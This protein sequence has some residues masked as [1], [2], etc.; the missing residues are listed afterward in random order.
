[1]TDH[2][3]TDGKR[4]LST[5][6][7]GIAALEAERDR[8]KDERGRNAAVAIER[9]WRA[10]NAEAE[11]VRLT[12]GIRSIA[13]RR[14]LCYGHS[15]TPGHGGPCCGVAGVRCA[16]CDARRLL[17]APHDQDDGCLDEIVR[18]SEDAG[19]YDMED[20]Q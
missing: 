19:L 15:R 18:V 9:R 1:M 13:A 16:T 20:G 8:L 3:V 11:V 5:T 6:Q 4:L 17:D 14:C 2:Y 7:R 12:D 10:E